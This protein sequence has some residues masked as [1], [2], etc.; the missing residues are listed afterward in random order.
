MR[1]PLSWLREYVTV[2]VPVEDLA[3]RLTMAG[4]EVGAIER[5]GAAWEQVVVGRIETLEPHRG[6][7]GLQVARVDIGG[8]A[9]T[10]VT[11]ATNLAAG[12]RVPV[13]LAGGAL[14]AGPIGSRSFD[15]VESQ[16]M[17]CSGA[18]LGIA[19]DKAGIYVLEAD[20][21]VGAAL[22]DYLGEV[23]LDLEITPNRPDLLS[24]VGVAREVGA[25]TGTPLHQPETA[26]P[27][28]AT[29]V[30]RFISV[31]IE[32]PDLCPRY[33]ATVVE[34]VRIGPSPA[35]LQRRL[36]LAGMR[37]ISNIV[38]VT[39]YVMLELGQP[40]HAFDAATLRGGIVVRRARPGERIRTIDDTEREL[41]PEML[42]IADAERP[43]AV[44]GVMGGAATEVSAATTRIVLES[45][46]FDPRSVRRTA[47]ALRLP[48]EASRR[49]E[50]GVDPGGTT[51]AA[52]RATALMA[53][54]AGGEAAAGHVDVHPAPEP[55]RMITVTAAGVSGLLGQHYSA[56]VIGATLRS[57]GF[58]VEEDL[59]PPAPLPSEGRGGPA[60][61]ARA[62]PESPPSP[63]GGRG[64]GG[65]GSALLV[66]VPSFRRDVEG[67]ADVAEEVVRIHGYDTIPTALPAG[68]LP[69]P[70]ADP[71][72]TLAEATKRTLV[73]CGYQEIITY[74]LVDGEEP[75]RL[76]HAAEWPPAPSAVGTG[77]ADDRPPQ[78]PNPGGSPGTAAPGRGIAGAGRPVG[79][80]AG[81]LIPVHN[82]MSQERGHLRATLL[83][84]LLETV[85]ANVRHRERVYLFEL[86]SVYRP[87]LD[88]LPAESQRL[89]LAL[90]G[91]RAP[92]AWNQPAEAGDFYDLKGAIESVL[93]ALWV[94]GVRF[95]P[96]RHSTL[97]PGRSAAVWAGDVR[98][99]VFG[100]VHPLVAERYELEARAVYAAELEFDA[101]V[102]VAGEQPPYTPLPR[103][104]GVA[105]DLAAVV[106]DAVPEAEVAAA[107]REAGSDLL[108]EVRLFDVYRG[109]PIPAGHKSL[110]YA[111]VY[112]APDR[113]LTDAA[114][115]ERQATVEAALRQRFGATIR[116]R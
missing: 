88:P 109:A 78:P 72:R 81:R 56:D 110:A 74:S 89:A 13:V 67:P 37:P 111:L 42:V 6:N 17:L 38:D 69:E 95:V 82:P 39:N 9:R 93:R 63:Y 98:L 11:G 5:V 54:L 40:L 65:K 107:I 68:R 45:A 85:A 90:T 47:R 26:P 36:H 91:P 35:W 97:H 113:T 100:Q 52:D 116:G 84:S 62:E 66:H 104:P 15:G 51:R 24:V 70:W 50:R 27:G 75:R 20:A 106:P 16:G 14:A 73:A 33:A 3:H 64:V 4:V 34:G 86:A 55:P 10:L 49:F 102:R 19:E 96:E 71:R 21:P 28:G 8:A 1:V 108:A 57:L 112:R 22:A 32:A 114:T 12:D 18:E 41:S 25:L 80:D 2:E 61:P 77:E 23:V 58:G 29:P 59:T 103:L 30:E 7:P 60:E 94:T 105:M 79:E 46:Y 115:A 87:P 48:S 99:G 31:T 43:I 92:A 44:A 53:Q 83:G 76:D 101:L